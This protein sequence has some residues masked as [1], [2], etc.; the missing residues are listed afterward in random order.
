MNPSVR[1]GLLLIALVI[2]SATGVSSSS[3]WAP[4][5]PA[6]IQ[7]TDFPGGVT[8]R[9]TAIAVNPFN[10]SQVWLGSA[11]GGVWFSPNRGLDWDPISDHEES[12]AI[13]AIAV[14]DCDSNGCDTLYVGTGE[15]A[16]RRDTYY[17]AGLLIGTSEG[18]DPPSY[19][20]TMVHGDPKTVDFRMASIHD[21]LY[22]PNT[23]G[24]SRILFVTLS[25][26]VTVS[27]TNSTV[28]APEPTL[29]GYGIYRSPDNGATWTKLSVA[30]SDGARPT[31][32]KMDPLQPYV[33]YAGF[34]GRGV[35]KSTTG[36]STWCPMNP[37]IDGGITCPASTG[38]PHI[39]T[40]FDQVDI[41]TYEQDS[42]VLYARFGY[43]EDQLV[44]SC[45][46]A[47]FKSSDGGSTWVQRWGG[48]TSGDIK[49]CP[50][51]Y[52]RYT[53]GLVVDP[54]NENITFAA[55]GRLCRSSFS[56]GS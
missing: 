29:G 43:C 12:L 42:D 13:G 50:S 40:N 16:I 15:N 39:D 9:A 49:T 18:G 34:L 35:F 53:H 1:A 4:I 28:T 8:G 52:S 2:A 54:S 20:W 48:S 36:G 14:A 44:K 46:P 7:G 26:G 22:N 21:V 47:F 6:P 11:A 31:D 38:L 10:G 23:S 5:G 25:S 17:G 51:A 33:M 37:G 30:H 27:S 19:D 45:T 56:A 41:A 24:D 55:G 32:L 3:G